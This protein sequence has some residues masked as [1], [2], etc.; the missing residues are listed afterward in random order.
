MKNFIFR[1]VTVLLVVAVSATFIE[2]NQV[3]GLAGYWIG[4]ISGGSIIALFTVFEE[5]RR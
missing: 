2:R 3:P 5:E 4:F 1:T